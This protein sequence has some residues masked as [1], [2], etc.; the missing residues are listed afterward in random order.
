MPDIWSHVTPLSELLQP[1]RPSVDW[2]DFNRDPT[3]RP[4][5]RNARRVDDVRRVR[6]LRRRPLSPIHKIPRRG[7][8][9]T[10]TP[11]C[12]V[13]QAQRGAA[14]GGAISR[15][16]AITMA[17]EKIV[18][19][20]SVQQA[21][22]RLVDAKRPAAAEQLL[23]GRANSAVASGASAMNLTSLRFSFRPA[24]SP[25]RHHRLAPISVPVP[26]PIE[27]SDESLR[28]SPRFN[29]PAS[30]PVKRLTPREGQFASEVDQWSR[31][32]A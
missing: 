15:D 10:H 20:V 9:L 13:P 32:W 22:K 5:L 24:S 23:R 28:R 18:E 21:A 6:D 11:M 4:C 3:E 17:E 30:S 31:L 2:Q 16:Q 25:V 8:T 12:I 26:A 7:T 1:Q 14:H 27:L 19:Q 29:R